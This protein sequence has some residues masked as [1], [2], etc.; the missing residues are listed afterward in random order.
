MD[1]IHSVVYDKV[2]ASSLELLLVE[3]VFI[4]AKKATDLSQYH[5]ATLRVLT[6]SCVYLSNQ[7]FLCREW[8]HP[9]WA[10]TSHIN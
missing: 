7:D 8:C 4:V 1:S 9:L 2:N 5:L 10:G 3:Y 6:M